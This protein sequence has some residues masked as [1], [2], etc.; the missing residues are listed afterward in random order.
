MKDLDWKYIRGGV[1]RH[2]LL[3][4]GILLIAGVTA[5]GW[6]YQLGSLLILL[7]ILKDYE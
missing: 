6:Q 3:V 5:S 1:I 4:G 7:Y 2:L